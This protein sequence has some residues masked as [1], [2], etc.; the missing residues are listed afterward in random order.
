MNGRVTGHSTPERHVSACNKGAFAAFLTV[1]GDSK[2]MSLKLTLAT[3]LAALTMLAASSALAAT[4]TTDL[5]VREEPDP[6]SEILGVLPEGTE[7]QCSDMVGSWCELA[8]GEGYV[9]GGY[10]DFGD[11]GDDDEDED[12]DEDEEDEEDVD[13]EEDDDGD[14]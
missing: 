7:V 13:E 9:Y 12:Q 5:N 10:L 2:K 11:N 4:V 6:E 1:H 14:Y 3:S 8:D